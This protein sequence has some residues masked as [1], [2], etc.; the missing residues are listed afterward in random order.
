[1]SYYKIENLEEYFK[2]Y[3]KSIREPKKFW[4]RI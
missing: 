4:D 3:K 1:M 2:H